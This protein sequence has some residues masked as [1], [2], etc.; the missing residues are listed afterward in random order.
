MINTLTF[1]SG[2]PGT[3]LLVLGAIHGNEVAGPNAIF[4]IIDDIQTYKI[5]LKTGRI[6]FVPICNL[7]AYDQDVR[8]IDENLN[9]IIK[10]HENPITYEQKLANEIVP[11]IAQCDALLDLHSTHCPGDVPFVFCDY[12]TQENM[13]MIDALDVQ[14]VLLGWPQI[15]T[16]CSDISDYSTERCA[17]ECHKAGITLECGYH[18]E[19]DSVIVAYRSIVNLLNMFG[20][21]EGDSL[22]NQDKTPIRLTEYVV[23]KKNG[24]LC[25]NYKHLDSVTQGQKIAEYDDGEILTAPQDG[26]ILLPNNMADIGTEWYYLGIK[27]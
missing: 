19:N 1:D 4:K 2:M 7:K 8:Q 3:H 13:K 26:Y 6:T 22:I 24:R 11:L 16:G 23:K 17:F 10:H 9:R 20:M 18:K 25:Q 5:H 21:I 12:P 27:E 15:Y 14:Y